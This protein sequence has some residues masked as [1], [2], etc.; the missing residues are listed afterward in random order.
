MTCLVVLFG[1]FN[2]PYFKAFALV[3][4]PP[5]IGIF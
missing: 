2:I 1:E 4:E 3:G 5:D